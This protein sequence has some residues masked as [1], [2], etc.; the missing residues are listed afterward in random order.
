VPSA[1]NSH[2][3]RPDH[4]G[5]GVGQTGPSSTT[6]ARTPTPWAFGRPTPPPKPAL[7]RSSS[8]VGLAL[9][10][11]CSAA[12]APSSRALAIHRSTG[13]SNSRN[14]LATVRN[15]N[16]R[17]LHRLVIQFR[18]FP[19]PRET[20]A[21]PGPLCSARPTH[22]VCARVPGG[23][24]PTT[25]GRCNAND[26]TVSEGYALRTPKHA[27]EVSVYFGLPDHFMCPHWRTPTQFH[28]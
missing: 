28:R 27:Y 12:R 2:T 18:V 1:A 13:G 10:R 15:K 5:G 17:A 16:L 11:S 25:V 21:A 3:R 22:F 8:D 20:A 24:I 6:P 9:G 23:R 19:A 7:R 26:I 14:G 4:A